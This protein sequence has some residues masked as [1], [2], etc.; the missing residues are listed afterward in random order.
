MLS[1]WPRCC[2]SATS[3]TRFTAG[4]AAA[5]AALAGMSLSDY[6]RKELETAVERLTPD[7]LRERLANLPPAAVRESP[8]DALR[9]R[10]RESL[11]SR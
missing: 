11:S 8:A 3:P 7:E 5:G 2:R 1:T 9:R 4:S 10:A 6:L